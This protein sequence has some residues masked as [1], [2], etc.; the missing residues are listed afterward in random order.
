ML[1]WVFK[2]LLIVFFLSMFLR[3]SGAAWGIGLLTVTSAVLLDA[4][5]QTWGRPWLLD[6][7]GFFSYVL[8]GMLLAGSAGWLW[9]LLSP[10][11]PSA[12]GPKMVKFTPRPAEPAALGGANGGAQPA[13]DRQLI[14]DQ[15]RHNLGPD[16]VLDLLFDLG[17]DENAVLNPSQEM[18][19][20][21]VA[22]MDDAEQQGKT[23]ALALAVERI[24]TPLPPQNLP[25]LEKISAESPP[26]ILR[27]FLVANYNLNQLEAI[28]TDLGLDWE[29]MGS[30]PKKTRVRLLLQH[31]TR[32][33]QLPKLIQRLHAPAPA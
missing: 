14:Y 19:R 25:R 11:T 12:T 2:A 13:V 1:F 17:M 7:L 28:V 6:N 31:I 21:I 5:G 33:N 32:R 27:Q 4:I 8:G 23:G 20:V 3:R 22:L 29:E 18:P 16:D 15:I 10:A 30:G 26:T 9:L 24:L